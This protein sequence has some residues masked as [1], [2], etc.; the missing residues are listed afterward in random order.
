MRH[1]LLSYHAVPYCR[2]DGNNLYN[3][4][5]KF[6]SHHPH[7]SISLSSNC[8]STI[9]RTESRLSIRLNH[10]ARA[11]SASVIRFILWC[12][13]LRS[14]WRLTFPLF[15]H[16]RCAHGWDSFFFLVLSKGVKKKIVSAA[17]LI[18]KTRKLTY[19]NNRTKEV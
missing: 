5:K 17:L 3:E 9:C 19:S 16:N 1:E 15:Y 6:L 7:P 10:V 18:Y 2:C 13:F 11:H 4:G 14:W 8:S 12:F